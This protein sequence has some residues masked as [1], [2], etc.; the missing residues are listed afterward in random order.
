MKAGFF[1]GKRCPFLAKNAETTA[2]KFCWP[3]TPKTISTALG[4][5][6]SNLIKLREAGYPVRFL[7]KDSVVPG[8]VEWVQEETG[9]D[10]K[11]C[12]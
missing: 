6:K 1:C 12:C 8:E 4:Q 7:Q 3:Y 10:E 11:P 9:K 5:K 2:G